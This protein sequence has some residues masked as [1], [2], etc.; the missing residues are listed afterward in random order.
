MPEIFY[1]LTGNAQKICLPIIVKRQNY[2]T[3][4]FRPAFQFIRHKKKAKHLPIL[5]KVTNSK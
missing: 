1:K 2:R 5:K 4:K 3:A